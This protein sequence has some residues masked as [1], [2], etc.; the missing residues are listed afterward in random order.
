MNIEKDPS[1]VTTIV[2]FGRTGSGKSSLANMIAGKK[3]FD[4]GDSLE[5]K[6][7]EAEME[8]VPWRFDP[9]KK[10]KLVDNP[11]FADNMPEMTN[12]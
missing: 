2:F 4:I 9:S 10:I 11:G 1:K 5:S 8:I 6:T 7:C 3:V 12:Q